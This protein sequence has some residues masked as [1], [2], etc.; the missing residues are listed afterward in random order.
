MVTR[1]PSESIEKL[2]ARV[3]AAREEADEALTGGLGILHAR[4]RLDAW[5]AML[6]PPTRD[7]VLAVV[8][9]AGLVALRPE[10][11]WH[12]ADK[13]RSRDFDPLRQRV[14]QEIER[15]LAAARY[16]P[17]TADRREARKWLR[18][19]LPLALVDIDDWRGNRV[20]QRKPF[21]I[22]LTLKRYEWRVRQIQR[23]FPRSQSVHRD[24]VEP[25]AEPLG[26][27][28][29]ELIRYVALAQRLGGRWEAIRKTAREWTAHELKI[30]LSLVPR[31]VTKKRRKRSPNTRFSA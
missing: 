26:V 25:L 13:E 3:R 12:D 28:V 24:D 15:V 11:W 8:R 22:R 21:E 20:P 1:R 23:L 18:D 14:W 2:A 29:A 4:D 7:A 9:E 6:D 10:R 27:E 30:P 19:A 5:M 16:A 31:I 17:S